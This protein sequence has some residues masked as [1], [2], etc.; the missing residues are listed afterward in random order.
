MATARELS[1]RLHADQVV[2]QDVFMSLRCEAMDQFFVRL[3][4]AAATATRRAMALALAL[5][6]FV[7]VVVSGYVQVMGNPVGRLYRYLR[8]A[9]EFWGVGNFQQLR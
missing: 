7:E 1:W 2:A 4:A 3:A 8:N 9:L 5:M 6:A